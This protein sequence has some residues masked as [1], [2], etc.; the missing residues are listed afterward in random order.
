MAQSDRTV[1]NATFPAVRADIND[2]LDAI[3]S[4]HSGPSAP[5]NPIIYQPWIDTSTSPATW[6]VF[7]GA[8][9]WV[10]IGTINTTTLTFTPGGVTAIANGG[11]GQT[12]AS[13]AINALLPSQS[14]NANKYLTTNGT[15]ASWAAAFASQVFEYTADNTWTKPSQGNFALVTIWGGG[16]SGGRQARAAGGG[17]GACVQRLYRLS[18]LP[19][20]VAVTIG[21]GGAGRSTDGDGSPGGTTTFGSLLSAYGGAGGDSTGAVSGLFGSGG[22]GSLSAGSMPAGAAGVG[23]TGHGPSLVGGSGYSGSTPDLAAR[24]ADFG[25]A[26]SGGVAS[27]GSPGTAGGNA[28]WGG[29]GGGGR[30]GNNIGTGGISLYGGNG[31]DGAIT[32]ANSN[33]GGFPGGGSGGSDA[34]TGAGGNGLC[35]IYVW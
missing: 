18:E 3:F 4:Q 6:K 20:S 28:Y 31:S 8:G 19:A 1:D 10:V 7:N 11:T 12:T 27:G 5:P 23:G 30:S 25:G 22:G 32:G 21:L 34:T 33:A 29:G 35:L 16:G 2:K 24:S 14:G 26:G 9:Q 17:G 13:N 15:I